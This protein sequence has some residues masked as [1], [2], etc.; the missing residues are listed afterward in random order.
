[1]SDEW[2]IAVWFRVRDGI[3]DRGE[4]PLDLKEGWWLGEFALDC[5]D[6]DEQRIFFSVGR[7]H[8]LNG[9]LGSFSEDWEATD[10]N[11][12]EWMPE[13]EWGFR[14]VYHHGNEPVAKVMPPPASQ[15][16]SKT[17][18]T[19]KENSPKPPEAAVTPA[20]DLES[21]S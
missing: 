13:S 7:S 17:Q 14:I 21:M 3:P 16:K 5:T 10:S 19:K 4:T 11:V 2:S 18:R 6:R 20:V 12:M 8:D 9:W 15:T 1:M